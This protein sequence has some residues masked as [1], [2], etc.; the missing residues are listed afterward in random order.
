MGRS[1]VGTVLVLVGLALAALGGVVAATFGP[2]GSLETTSTPLTTT[3]DGYALVADVDAVTA[4]FPGSGLIGTPTLGA[5]SVGT[6]RLFIG[7]GGRPDVDEYL[8]GVAFEAVRQDGDS[9][10]SLAIPGGRKPGIPTD[11][12]FWI[13]R[14]TG[15]APT[16]PFTTTNSGTTF[17]VMRDDGTPEVNARIIVGY[18]SSYVFPGAIAMVVIGLGL[19]VWGATRLRRRPDTAAI[20]DAEGDE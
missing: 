19:L 11:E 10:Q 17:V 18:T 15:N 9:W 16:V 13:R 4:G 5:D 20:P 6:D 14:A 8:S 3:R 7:L 12:Q 2:A 1:A